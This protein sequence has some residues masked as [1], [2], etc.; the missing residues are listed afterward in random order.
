MKK[1]ALELLEKLTSGGARKEDRLT[2]LLR[3]PETG[4][5]PE[6][7]MH[8]PTCFNDALDI[9]QTTRQINGS[10]VGLWTQGAG[11][12]FKTGDLLYDSPSEDGVWSTVVQNIKRCVQVRSATDATNARQSSGRIAGT[13]LF[14]VLVPNSEK[15]RLVHCESHSVTQ[16]QFVSYLIAGSL[17]PI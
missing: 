7:F 10:A 6:W 2:E 17:P 1:P 12:S 16:D 5:S 13:V 11:F 15:T 8:V 14:D 9:R 4:M 3:D